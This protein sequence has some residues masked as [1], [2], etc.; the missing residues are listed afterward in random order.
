MARCPSCNKFVSFSD[1]PEV[2]G[3]PDVIVT[4]DP[5]NG[6]VVVRLEGEVTVSLTCDECGTSLREASFEINQELREPF[7][8]DGTLL[9]TRS[10][11]WHLEGGRWVARL[12]ELDLD[13][14]EDLSVEVS[15]QPFTD[16]DNKTKK[17]TYGMEVSVTVAGHQGSEL[18][19]GS[20][21]EARSSADFDEGF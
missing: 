3:E 4:L 20:Y 19:V 9:L 18:L 6:D 15:V 10:A 16:Y 2:S 5:D 12:D 21:Q 8:A 14:E 7:P 13:S 17:T 11:E 1:E